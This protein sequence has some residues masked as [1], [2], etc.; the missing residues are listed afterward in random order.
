MEAY[1]DSDFG[2]CLDTR[3]SVSGAV[4]SDAGKGGGQLALEDASSNGVGYL[5]G[6]VRCLV[7]G[8]KGG[9]IFETSAEFH[10][11]VI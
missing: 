6:G 8:G 1:T 4:G 9:C 11:T 5:G 2:A 3:R 7:R 10:V